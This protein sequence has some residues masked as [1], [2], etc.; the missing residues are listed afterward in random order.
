MLTL[1]GHANVPKRALFDVYS[2]RGVWHTQAPTGCGGC[3]G[4]F[5]NCSVCGNNTCYQCD[6]PLRLGDDGAACLDPGR[7]RQLPAVDCDELRDLGRPTGV[8]WLRGRANVRRVL[9]KSL[10]RA[11]FSRGRAGVDFCPLSP[12]RL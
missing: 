3:D 12:L 1:C 4:L 9:S 2:R 10:C 8:Y 6:P 7:N 5:P 11:P